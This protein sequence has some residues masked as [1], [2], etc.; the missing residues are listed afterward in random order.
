MVIEIGGLEEFD[1]RMV[2]R[3]DIHVLV[4]AVHQHAGEKKIRKHDNPFE[5]E[6]HGV[7]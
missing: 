7:P 2:P 1:V 5:T 4:D 3:D 6:F